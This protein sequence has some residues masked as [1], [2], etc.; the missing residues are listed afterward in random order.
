VQFHAF[1]IVL[2]SAISVGY[3]T[4]VLVGP[5]EHISFCIFPER[6]ITRENTGKVAKRRKN[7]KIPKCCISRKYTYHGK[8]LSHAFFA[9]LDD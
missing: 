4:L 3:E 1:F 5:N 7:E 6:E 9:L 8:F 2:F